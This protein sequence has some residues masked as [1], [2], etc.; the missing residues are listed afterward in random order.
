MV[1][2]LDRHHLILDSNIG[3]MLREVLD[4][5]LSFD[6]SGPGPGISATAGLDEKLET[7]FKVLYLRPSTSLD[8]P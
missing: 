7:K 2:L 5:L 6:K 1:L 8:D 4:R 3:S